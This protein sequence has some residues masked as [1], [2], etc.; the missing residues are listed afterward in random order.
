MIEHKILYYYLGFLCFVYRGCSLV[1]S[2]SNL[3][4]NTD[5]SYPIQVYNGL[6]LTG[7]DNCLYVFGGISFGTFNKLNSYKFNITPGTPREWIPINPMPI[8]VEEA[9]GCVANDGR[10]FIFG[11]SEVNTTSPNSIQ[12]YNATSNSWN[13][14]LPSL[15]PNASISDYSMSCAINRNTGLMYLIGGY[16]D[17]SRFYSYDVNS[18]QIIN[19][20]PVAFNL[21]GPG[22]FLA[23]NGNLYVFG[24]SNGTRSSNLIYIYNISSG[25]LSTGENLPYPPVNFGS[26]FDGQQIY[27]I[28][29]SGLPYTQVY[30][31]TDNTWTIGSSSFPVDSVYGNTAAILEG[32]LH[33]IGGVNGTTNLI[34]SLCGVYAFRGRCDNQNQCDF[35]D[36][37]ERNGTCI[38][39]SICTPSQ[40]QNFSCNST[41]GNCV[42]KNLDNGHLC[43]IN[44]CIENATCYNLNC[45]GGVPVVCDFSSSC[46][47]SRTCNP[48]SGCNETDCSDDTSSG[49]DSND[50]MNLVLIITVAAL[51][52]L[53]TF[54]CVIV[55]MKEKEEY[56]FSDD[57]DEKSNPEEAIDAADE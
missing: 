52:V 8:P 38:G 18:N 45:T 44:M 14:I 48:V 40:C 30:N 9:T 43:H 23:S 6:A 32:S 28:G 51:V 21:T 7:Y 4:W 54:Y 55:K 50:Q 46:S 29:G 26:A 25:K 27:V 35:N 11:G 10:F 22:S 1:R 36:I 2:S 57:L 19:L 47:S 13:L 12:V 42:Y 16:S 53:A 17:S 56:I 3:S 41:T 24:G 37:C 34:A 39:T 33:S 5:I 31:I 49:T 20:F 15:P